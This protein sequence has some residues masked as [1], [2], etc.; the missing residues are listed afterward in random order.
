MYTKYI[1]QEHIL[2]WTVSR[3]LCE[4]E[5]ERDETAEILMAIDLEGVQRLAGGLNTTLKARKNLIYFTC[6]IRFLIK[7]QVW[8]FFSLF[9]KYLSVCEL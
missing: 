8:S 9:W 3:F 1:E 2:S 4:R 6:L 5:S 7:S